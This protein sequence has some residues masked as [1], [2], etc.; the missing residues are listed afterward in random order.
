MPLH[1]P[2][3]G[4]E[5]VPRAPF[6]RNFGD[7]NVKRA[8]AFSSGYLPGKVQFRRR[9][10]RLLYIDQSGRHSSDAPVAIVKRGQDLAKFSLPGKLTVRNAEFIELNELYP[11]FRCVNRKCRCFF[12]C[13]YLTSICVVNERNKIRVRWM[14]SAK[15]LIY[16]EAQHPS[17]PQIVKK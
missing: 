7:A 9:A 13:H 11:L 17:T 5:E 6:V 12:L 2:A 15:F 4:K 1:P 14:A 16:Y 3:V 8:A 10:G